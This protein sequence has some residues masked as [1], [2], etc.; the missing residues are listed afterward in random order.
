MRSCSTPIRTRNI[1]IAP[2]KFSSASSQSIPTITEATTALISWDHQTCFPYSRTF[3]KMESY[4][5]YSLAHGFFLQINFLRF[6]NAVVYISNLSI[7]YWWEMY[8][9]CPFS[10]LLIDIWA[11]SSFFWLY[12]K[13][14]PRTF[15]L[16]IFIDIYFY[17]S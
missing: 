6:I 13:K 8:T 10:P 4:N 14:L 17:F 5:K 12:E 1:S 3:Y 2:R 15:S 7:F 11:V 16:K 9:V